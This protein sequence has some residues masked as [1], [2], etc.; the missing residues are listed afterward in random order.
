MFDFNREEDIKAS[1]PQDNVMVV[2]QAGTIQNFSPYKLR[3]STL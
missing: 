2:N 1:F 3:V